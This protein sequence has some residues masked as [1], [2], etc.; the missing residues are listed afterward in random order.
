MEFSIQQRSLGKFHSGKGERSVTSISP[1]LSPPLVKQHGVLQGRKEKGQ[2]AKL[3]RRSVCLIRSKAIL[4]NIVWPGEEGNGDD[5]ED[6]EDTC[7]KHLRDRT[8]GFLRR[9]IET[10]SAEKLQQL[11]R[12]WV[13][14]E[15]PSP[16]MKVEVVRGEYLRAS[17]CFLT[18][19][20]PGHFHTYEGFCD[21]ME[22]CIATHDTVFGLI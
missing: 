8:T 20:V 18:L 17:T 13:G 12:F 4:S 9:F 10:A 11:I 7:P 2:R 3:P 6:D 15:V 21:H 14:W 5:D 16:G 19:R 22:C 1:T